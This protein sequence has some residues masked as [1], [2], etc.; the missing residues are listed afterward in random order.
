MFLNLTAN[1]LQE[2]CTSDGAL[3]SSDVE[4]ISSTILPCSQEE[5][6]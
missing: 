5:V 2:K 1:G 3:L 4:D 6:Y